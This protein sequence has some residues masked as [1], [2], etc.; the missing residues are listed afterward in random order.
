LYLPGVAFMSHRLGWTRGDG[1]AV[2]CAASAWLIAFAV[3]GYRK[4]NFRCPR[5]AEPFFYKFDDRRWRMSWQHNPFALRCMHC[6]LP[7]WAPTASNLNVD[8]SPGRR[9]S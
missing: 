7:K 3:I 9:S 1:T 6:G 4:W 2:L 5:C 8:L